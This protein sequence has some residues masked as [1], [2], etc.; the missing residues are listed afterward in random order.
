[1]SGWLCG[2]PLLEE[3]RAPRTTSRKAKVSGALAALEGYA[4]ARAT[5]PSPTAV[6]PVR[7]FCRAGGW[8]AG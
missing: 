3:E 6:E 7:T 1:M 5:P 8:P 2:V 4:V